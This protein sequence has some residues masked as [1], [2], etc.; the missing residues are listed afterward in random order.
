MSWL[1]GGLPGVP[2]SLTRVQ[3]SPVS[4]STRKSDDA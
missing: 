1:I 3:W 4:G 2:L